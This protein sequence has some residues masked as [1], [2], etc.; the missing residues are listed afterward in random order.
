LDLLNNLKIGNLLNFLIQLLTN[1]DIKSK[2]YKIESSLTEKKLMSSY[3]GMV[4]YEKYNFMVD[5]NSTCSKCKKGFFETQVVFIYPKTV[6]HLECYKSI[7]RE[8]E[9]FNNNN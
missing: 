4:E 2:D 7:Y 1:I 5:Q 9:N 3:N 8:K 6:I